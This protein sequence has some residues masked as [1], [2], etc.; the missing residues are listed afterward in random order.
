MALALGIFRTKMGR[1]FLR[2]AHRKAVFLVGSPNLLVAL[3][4]RQEGF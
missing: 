3:K 4:Y 1:Q 2:L